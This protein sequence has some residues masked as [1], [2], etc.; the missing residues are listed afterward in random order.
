ME[1]QQKKKKSIWV[2]LSC[3]GTDSEQAGKVFTPTPVSF[4][5]QKKV[6]AI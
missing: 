4:E 2:I 3:L 6:I 5:K 1:I